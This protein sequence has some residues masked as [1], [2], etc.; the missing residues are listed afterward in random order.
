MDAERF[1]ASRWTK[2]NHIFP[3][4]I[5]VTEQSVLRRKRSW[6]SVNEE[7]VHIRNVANVNITTG[8]IW[9]TMHIESSGGSDPITSNGHTKGDARRIKER[10]EQLQARLGTGERGASPAA[11]ADGDTKQCPFCAETIKRAARL[12]RYCNRDLV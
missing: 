12:C 8:L 11:A 10:I 3:T 5:E 7:S 1:T 4:R 9:S 2:G 6:L